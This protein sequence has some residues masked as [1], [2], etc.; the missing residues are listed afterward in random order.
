MKIEESKIKKYLIVFIIINCIAIL[1]FTM[2]KLRCFEVVKYSILLNF[3]I[4]ISYIDIKEKIIPNLSLKILFIIAILFIIYECISNISNFKVILL[5]YLFGFIAGGGIFFIVKIINKNSIG[6]G[7][8]KLISVLSL[9]IGFEN[10]ISCMVLSLLL[11]SIFSIIFLII[12]KITLK[13]SVPFAPFIT[14][15]LII[16]IVLEL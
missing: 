16:S 4:Y 2:C 15:A 6:M 11:L 3:L 8:V 14:V 13:D 12:K 7:D 10:V 9:F 5:D 1:Y